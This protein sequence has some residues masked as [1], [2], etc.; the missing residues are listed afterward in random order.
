MFNSLSK[1]KVIVLLLVD[2]I[3]VLLSYLSTFYFISPYGIERFLINTLVAIAVYIV[4]L[5]IFGVYNHILRYSSV[6]EYGITVMASVTAS[7]VVLA[8]TLLTHQKFMSIKHQLFSGI[9]APVG[10]VA[11][12]VLMRQNIGKIHLKH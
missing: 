6:R 10:F 1:K 7:I 4:I 5:F 2:A 8:I 11:F 9:I 12:R 3:I